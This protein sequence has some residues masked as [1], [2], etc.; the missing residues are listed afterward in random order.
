MQS[1]NTHSSARGEIV[2][3]LPT[4]LMRVLAERVEGWRRESA[5]GRILI[6][7]LDG[8]TAAALRDELPLALLRLNGKAAGLFNADIR[9][10]SSFATEIA[11]ESLASDGVRRLP[12]NAAPAVVAEAI[13]ETLHETSR[14]K[15]PD[16]ENDLRL[17]PSFIR[18][19][20]SAIIDMKKAGWSPEDCRLRGEGRFRREVAT[21]YERSEA[22][23]HERRWA[24]PTDVIV[25][26]AS[27]L[28]TRECE[29]RP[30]VAVFGVRA[31]NRTERDLLDALPEYAESVSLFVP[32]IDNAPAFALASRTIE[33]LGGASGFA[34]SHTPSAALCDRDA[35]IGDL[36]RTDR[37]QLYPN[38]QVSFV[39]APDS[40]REWTDTARHIMSL[41]RDD[42]ALRFSDIHVV[43]PG[44][45]GVRS[46]VKD[47]F[48]AARIPVNWLG[49]IP[50]TDTEPGRSLL[51]ILSASESGFERSS[52]LELL[53]TVRLPQEWLACPSGLVSPAEW[54][55]LLNAAGV[56]G[57]EVRANEPLKESVARQWIDPL[58]R[59]GERLRERA[60]TAVDDPE[61]SESVDV[62]GTLRDAG[63]CK[64]FVSVIDQLRERLNAIDEARDTGS[65]SRWVD[66]VRTAWN[67]VDL[68]DNPPNAARSRIEEI[69]DEFESYDGS[70]RLPA[71]DAL[72]DLVRS[73]LERTSLP[74]RSSEK[75]DADAAG[76][77]LV[78]SDAGVVVSD[79]EAALFHAPRIMMVTGLVDGEYPP[80]AEHRPLHQFAPEPV[81]CRTAEHS[82]QTIAED[83]A[84]ANL[85]FTL[86][87][88]APRDRV[89]LS[90]AR[91][92]L[93][94]P[95]RRSAC[96]LYLDAASRALPASTGNPGGSAW[97]E[98]GL[99]Q[100]LGE[101]DWV[102]RTAIP[103][104]SN[105]R[106][107]LN[108]HEFD[109]TAAVRLSNAEQFVKYATP[110]GSPAICLGVNLLAA[111]TE[112]NDSLYDGLIYDADLSAKILSQLRTGMPLSP[113]RIEQ[114]ARCPFSYFVQRVLG[115]RPLDEPDDS[116]ELDARVRGSM[117]HRLLA[118]FFRRLA[119]EGVTLSAISE[120]DLRTRFDT[121]AERRHSQPSA[122]DAALPGLLWSAEWTELC[123]RAWNAVALLHTESAVWEPRFHEFALGMEHQRRNADRKS[124]PEPVRIDLDGEAVTLQGIVDRV[125][126]SRDG[127]HAR[128][129]DYKSGKF[130]KAA[131]ERLD[132]G[133]TLQLV[134]YALGL[135]Q[136]MSRT[137]MNADVAEAMYHYLREPLPDDPAKRLECRQV[138]RRDRDE[139]D[140]QTEELREVLTALFDSVQQGVFH[141]LPGEPPTQRFNTCEY[142][143]VQA[144][145][146]SLIDLER[147]WNALVNADSTRHFRDVLRVEVPRRG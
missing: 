43:T 136:W 69:L 86:L 88:S 64:T 99:R 77:G 111:R 48:A 41:V 29:E 132:G 12:R 5:F 16:P 103:A 82:V 107:Y 10:L 96:S 83:I 11:S 114:Y 76:H 90:Y 9:T 128:V 31:L 75:Q 93:D 142:C 139:L 143:D 52:I 47:V 46:I 100:A 147:R 8:A 50:V 23:L 35:L 91:A 15:G 98:E 109:M 22:I 92:Q 3:G 124:D 108:E 84:G 130:E 78:E 25:R 106:W 54:D 131:L 145:C 97:P 122:Q 59:H 57:R 144:A 24:D 74:V 7:T 56:V 126:M 6:L 105:G 49:G 137:G 42:P 134:V 121:Y 58:L 39:S 89:R 45:S 60:E 129:V 104:I 141:P 36:L 2:T 40:V 28:R 102:R 72:G 51:R 67:A 65:W 135:S 20:L 113:S 63:I 26:A 44:L 117:I 85:S 68:P 34:V 61:L 17:R 119:N 37:R 13:Q 53:T 27:E 18:A 1:G 38:A 73:A 81:E 55:R 80:A 127:T 94:E 70:F 125:D 32:Y 118:G 66:A 101:H 116:L 112:A 33:A 62:S 110:E 146:G 21:I 4:P 123:E 115:I 138:D 19:V 79:T 120:S 140:R 95:E 71:R 133:R 14:L 87:L 30:R